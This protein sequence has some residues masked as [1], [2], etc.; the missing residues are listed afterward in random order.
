MSKGLACLAGR[1]GVSEE[2]SFEL[3]SKDELEEASFV[4]FPVPT[5]IVSSIALCYFPS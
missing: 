2:V 1:G 3:R 4:L 5:L